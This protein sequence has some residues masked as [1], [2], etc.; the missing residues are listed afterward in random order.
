MKYVIETSRQFDGCIYTSMRDGIH[1]DYGGETIDEI[2]QSN[3]GRTFEVIENDKL[4]ELLREYI[5]T[6][7]SDPFQEI[8]EEQYW[9]YMECVPPARSGRNWFFLGEAYN[10]DVHLFCFTDG[11]RYFSGHRRITT[12][13]ADIEAEIRTFLDANPVSTNA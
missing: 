8:T 11:E 5:K 10:Y 12:Q 2:R 4:N 6:I 7:S 3:P 9:D 13:R 1:S